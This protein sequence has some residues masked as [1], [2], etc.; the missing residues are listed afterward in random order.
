MILSKI[1]SILKSVSLDKIQELQEIIS[2]NTWCVLLTASSKDGCTDDIT[3]FI[4]R[5]TDGAVSIR[6]RMAVLMI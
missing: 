5:L 2:F 1:K 3:R 6:V 4:L